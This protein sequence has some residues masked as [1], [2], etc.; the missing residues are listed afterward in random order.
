MRLIEQIE[1][2][3]DDCV[4]WGL[5]FTFDVEAACGITLP[6][7]SDATSD[8]IST[9]TVAT[10]KT[11]VAATTTEVETKATD[12]ATESSAASQTTTT[13]QPTPVDNSV[14][15]VKVA[16]GIIVLPVLL[17]FLW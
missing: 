17:G 16:G 7:T 2:S 11:S 5:P 15:K 13:S 1:R 14:S 12:S 4:A 10:V 8:A 3:G 9:T 6:A